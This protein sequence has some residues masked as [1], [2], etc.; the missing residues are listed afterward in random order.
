MTEAELER[1]LRE[2]PSEK[3]FRLLEEL[4]RQRKENKS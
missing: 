1:L 2:T 4:R 3:A